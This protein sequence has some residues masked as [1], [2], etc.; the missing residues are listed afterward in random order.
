M[1]DLITDIKK[2][3][4]IV[5]LRSDELSYDQQEE[6][7]DDYWSGGKDGCYHVN[8]MHEK[9]DKLLSEKEKEDFSVWC[10]NAQPDDILNFMERKIATIYIEKEIYN[11]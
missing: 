7:Y 11:V 8:Q 9:F 3:I 5:D 2:L 6:I 10:L 1:K 4:K